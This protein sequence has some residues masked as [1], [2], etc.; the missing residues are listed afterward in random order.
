[1]RDSSTF[2]AQ[3][4]AGAEIKIIGLQI[5]R[6]LTP[7]LS[8]FAGGESCFELGC[9]R[10][11]ELALQRE[12]VLQLAIVFLR[13]NLGVR[14]GVDELSVDSHAIARNLEASLQH[15][16]NAQVAPDLL[17]VSILAPV[18]CDT[19]AADDLQV[20]PLCRDRSEYCPEHHRQNMT[21]SC[22]RPGFR[23]AGLQYFSG[24]PRLAH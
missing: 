21:E 16:Y 1:M 23:R 10:L 8:L 2:T 11:R 20:S 9:D 17:H 19:T 3:G 5:L 15:V 6:G 22:S 12:D 18:A 24:Y 7:N 14:L 13:P 4:G